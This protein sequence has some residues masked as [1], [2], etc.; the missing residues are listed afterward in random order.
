MPG[1]THKAHGDGVQLQK[2]KA[3]V[4]TNVQGARHRGQVP[5]GDVLG[6]TSLPCTRRGEACFLA[7]ACSSFQL[8]Y[9]TSFLLS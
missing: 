4:V 9:F 5:R 8:P 3:G 1:E 6:C 2:K 7:Q